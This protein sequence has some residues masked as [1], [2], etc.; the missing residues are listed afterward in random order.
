M[1]MIKIEIIKEYKCCWKV[2]TIA[3]VPPEFAQTLI[4]HGYAKAVDKP[5]RN[6]MVESP[7]NKKQGG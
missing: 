6:K 3:D 2:G 7:N 5:E 4:E 1:A